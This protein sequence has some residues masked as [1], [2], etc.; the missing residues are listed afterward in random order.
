[1]WKPFDHVT[2]KMLEF[3]QC[4]CRCHAVTRGWHNFG[5]VAYCRHCS[6]PI[7][8]KNMLLTG[9]GMKGQHNV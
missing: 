5:P 1:M 3:Y 6:D 7:A 4:A 8:V 9:A 2:I